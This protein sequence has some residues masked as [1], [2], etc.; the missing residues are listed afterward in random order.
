MEMLD[1]PGDADALAPL[2]RLWCSEPSVHGGNSHALALL[3][4]RKR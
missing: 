1:L 3:S 4:A 2:R